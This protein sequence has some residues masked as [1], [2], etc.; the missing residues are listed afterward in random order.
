MFGKYAKAFLA[1]GYAAVLGY[2]D[3]LVVDPGPWQKWG[4]ALVAVLTAAG[5]AV[6]PRNKP[7]APADRS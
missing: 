6:G 4:M 1:A 5:V 3:L 2:L 7:D